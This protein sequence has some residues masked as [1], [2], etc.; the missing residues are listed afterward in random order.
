MF[1]IVLTRIFGSRNDRLLRT[2]LHVLDDYFAAHP[3]APR[4]AIGDLSRPQGG[5]FDERY[6]GLGHA[7]HQNG[8]DIDIYYPRLDRE[9]RAPTKPS[10][11][12]R[13]LAQDLVNRF[14]RAGATNIFVGPRL[15]LRG[16]M[17]IPPPRET[18]DEQLE[19][20]QRLA[21]CRHALDR[22]GL[23]LDTLSMGMS[24]DL[25]AAVAAGATWVR[26]GT[27]IFGERPT[28]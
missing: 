25:E 2:L 16:I 27:A 10:E 22:E 20:F 18:F 6:G 7:S 15:A 8:R 4:I 1:H 13:V 17:C 9:E 14:V 21:D 11:V 19:L 12:D 24:A 3:D 26:I 23:T 28:Q 5:I